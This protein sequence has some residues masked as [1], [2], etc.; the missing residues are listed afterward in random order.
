MRFITFAS[1]S[2]GNCTLV[3][4]GGASV[5]VDA[6]ISLRR[7]RAALARHGLTA[8]DLDAVVITHDHSDH[9][10]ALKTLTKNHAVPVY[11]PKRTVSHLCGL[12]PDLEGRLR[13][14]SPG[15]PITV[16]ELK[17]TA[18]STSH[19]AP[20]SVGYVLESP[21]GRIGMCTDT[22]V[23]TDEMLEALTG[24]SAALI[25]ANHDRD[26]LLQGPYPYP[27][28]RRIRSET[29]HLSNDESASL[30]CALAAGGAESIVL[31]H[32]SRENNTPRLAFDT[33][34]EALDAEG[35]ASVA[36]SVAPP[37]GEVCVEITRCSVSR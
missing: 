27:L 37:E 34:R 21:D 11:V 12:V 18:F 24:C 26:R 29:G 36:L 33:V 7:I 32:L 9:V 35:Y 22:G 28:K 19:D 8:D 15:E 5:L 25:E 16:G 2:G 1:G 14:L 31:G 6:G 10:C 17:I 23:V 3:Q 13:P 30:A 4:G 20:G